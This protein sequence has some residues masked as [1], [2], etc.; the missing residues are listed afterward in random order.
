M[1]HKLINTR[2]KEEEPRKVEE[3]TSLGFIIKLFDK[4]TMKTMYLKVKKEKYIGEIK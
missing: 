3:I 1:V 4:K 2:R